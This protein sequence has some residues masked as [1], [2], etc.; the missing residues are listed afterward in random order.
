MKTFLLSWWKGP[1]KKRAYGFLSLLLFFCVLDVVAN[2]GFNL[3]QKNFFNALEQKQADVFISE[4]IRFI[5]L[6]FLVLF[7]FAGNRFIKNYISFQW[8]EYLTDYF[9]K[10][11]F[12][13]K[14]YYT[15]KSEFGH[16]DNVDQ[17]I[18]QD[19]KESTEKLTDLT[20]V[21]LKDGLN[22]ITFSFILYELSKLLNF[23]IPGFLLYVAFLYAF[24]AIFATFKLGK[25]L[26]PL[27]QEQEKRE[28]DFRYLLMRVHEYASD[29]K[30]AKDNSQTTKTLSS[31]FLFI[32]QN[33]FAILR[34]KFFVD[35]FES[36]HGQL[37]MFIP[38]ILTS[39]FYFQG[40]ISL[41]VLIQIR[42]MFYEVYR[43]LAS[44]AY[45]F[46]KIAHTL[47]SLNRLKEL[48]SALIAV[49]ENQ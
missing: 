1:D 15:I 12:L 10:L 26:I 36:I 42:G 11:W 23:Y 20:G 14:S 5:P 47:A 37:N 44:C 32:K 6:W 48:H 38:L 39:P 31:A 3:W 19:I 7:S 27:D 21:F 40:L 24:L 8:R 45:E 22:V 35:S 17:R 25:P 18:A 9:S 28:A 29:L 49:Q 41:G 46:E 43:S 30:Q 13:N 16:V 4:I 33:Y 2:V 34:R